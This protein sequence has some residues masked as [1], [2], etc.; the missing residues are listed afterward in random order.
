MNLRKN[1][2]TMTVDQMPIADIYA[3]WG[4]TENEHLAK[5]LAIVEKEKAQVMGTTRR[6]TATEPF[7][8]VRLAFKKRAKCLKAKNLKNKRKK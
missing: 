5:M 7:A 6:R 8:G 4:T 1:A 3:A 2:G